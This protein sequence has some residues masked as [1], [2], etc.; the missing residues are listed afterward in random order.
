[1]PI[2]EAT[3]DDTD[4]IV[5]LATKFLA[6]TAYGRILTIST[7]QLEQLIPTVLERGVIFVATMVFDIPE[8]FGSPADRYQGQAIVGF[9][10]AI[11]AIDPYSGDRYADEIAW[12]VTPEARNGSYG[13]R[14]LGSLEKWA[15]AKRLSFV[16]MVAPADQ[17][18]VAEFYKTIGY[19][20][21][22][23]AFIKRL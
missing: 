23:S 9:L 22:E 17:P 6:T 2:R 12:F 5:T 14:L 19:E 18:G 1:M 16:K 3:L 15:L 7:E 21:L 4:A 13:P 11:E 8:P 20:A 10:A